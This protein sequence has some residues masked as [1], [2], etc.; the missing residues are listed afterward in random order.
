[1]IAIRSP[2]RS[3]SSTAKKKKKDK[4]KE[5]KQHKKNQHPLCHTDK[6]DRTATDR[7]TGAGRGD[8]SMTQA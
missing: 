3:A 4:E 2:R 5:R 6:K 8:G 1:M 7:P